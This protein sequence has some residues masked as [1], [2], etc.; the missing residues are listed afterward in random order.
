MTNNDIKK[1]FRKVCAKCGDRV[2]NTITINHDSRTVFKDGL[3]IGSEGAEYWC[4]SC[5]VHSVIDRQ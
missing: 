4:L 5:V 2:T 1:D 3:E